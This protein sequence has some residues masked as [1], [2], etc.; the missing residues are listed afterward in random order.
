MKTKN[1]NDLDREEYPMLYEIFKELETKGSIDDSIFN[2]KYTK[3]VKEIDNFIK[4]NP[5]RVTLNNSIKPITK[6]NSEELLNEENIQ[7][8]L[9]IRYSFHD[10]GFCIFI[11]YN[12]NDDIE[13]PPDYNDFLDLLED[14]YTTSERNDEEKLY[15]KKRF[16]EIN[17]KL[18][19]KSLN[20]DFTEYG[21]LFCFY[22]GKEIEYCIANSWNILA[23]YS[24]NDDIHIEK[25]ES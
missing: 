18:S 20:I 10:Y 9:K 25:Y 5:V 16:N 6:I 2:N 13:I 19:L 1:Y 4:K 17:N 8:G 15:V 22:L 7:R 12:I 11:D 23:M 24:W 3:F 21:I 14:R